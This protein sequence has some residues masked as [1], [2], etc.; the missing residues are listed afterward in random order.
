MKRPSLQST[1]ALLALVVL[2]VATTSRGQE[3]TLIQDD[4]ITESPLEQP[5][6]PS[7]AATEPLPEIEEGQTQPL[8]ETTTTPNGESP[9]PPAEESP[10]TSDDTIKFDPSKSVVR[11]AKVRPK[12]PRA[13]VRVPPAP[14]HSANPE[15]DL[16]EHAQLVAK[17][18][19]WP[20]AER[21]Y[22]VYLETYPHKPNAQAAYYG[23][24]EARMKLGKLAESEATYRMLL[25]RFK[26]GEHVGAAAYRLGYIHWERQE[27]DI[28]V[29]NFEIAS[30]TA[31]KDLVRKSASYFRAQ[32]LQQ[33][34]NL[35]RAEE[36]FL[37]LASDPEDHKYRDASAIMLARID[38]EKNKFQQAYETFSK[39]SKPPTPPKIRAEAV[40]K[41]GLM[42]AKLGMQTEAQQYYEEILAV[43]TQDATPWHPKAF[44]GLLHLFYEQGNYQELIDQ[45]QSRRISYNNSHTG[46]EDQ[47]PVMLMVAHAFRR[48]E[49]YRQAA[50]LYDQSVRLNPDAKEAREAGYRHLYCLYKD[51]SPFLDAKTHDYL[52]K[53][54]QKG[55]GHQYYHLALLLKAESLFGRKQK[56]KETY[57]EAA[58]AYAAI[59]LEMIP[60]KY[61]GM[62]MYK[63]GWAQ[64]EAGM[65]GKGIQSFYTFSTKYG[66][67]YPDLLPK[68]LAKRGEAFRKGKDYRSAVKDFD[69]LIA[70]NADENLV[71]LALQQ[72]ALIQVELENRPE[73]IKTFTAL[74][75]RFPD[76]Q[77]SSEAYFFIGDAHYKQSEFEECVEPLSKARELDGDTYTIPSTQRII[78]AH[79]RL[80]DS[81]NAAKQVDLLL[82]RDPKTNLIPP[83]LWLWLGTRFFQQDRFEASARYLKQVAKPD[84]PKDTWPLAW[85]F[86]GRAYLNSGKYE[87]SLAP[88]DHY[89][90]TEPTSDE[91]AKALLHKAT[92]LSKTGKLKEAQAAAEEVQQLQK[93]GRTYGQAW[94]LL[95]DIAMAQSEHEKASKYYVIPS[96]MF[97]DPLV[98]PIAIEKAAVAFD[99]MGEAQ[100]A[101][102]LRRKL[103]EDWPT[104]QTPADS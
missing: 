98:T 14:K 87:E 10:E 33:L 6:D 7:T 57:K 20:Q 23:L 36:L 70:T 16:F 77:G 56:T 3:P 95:G 71:Y 11:P 1:L 97:K 38:V 35:R 101:A 41:A 84:A 13:P 91:R 48:L 24:A 26:R 39:L 2:L 27:Y 53:Q 85:S 45:F 80:G 102:D 63:L 73:T 21:Q 28:A 86:L 78:V 75:D 37:K 50:S 9:T 64:T 82:A 68:V 8:P 25:S 55:I 40:T 89:L 94:I 12:A 32:C 79:W 51:K 22:R 5:R 103:R 18:E 65:H 19:L 76:G 72:K 66:E 34:G 81:D 93:Q 4:Q 15:A 46:L 47:A 62:V 43:E 29:G 100:R 42:A 59:N 44:W 17:Y 74:L 58:D 60:E 54:R 69:A 61:H 52:I 83:K 49:K 104:Y 90:A 99:K 67:Q 31:T 88:F 30:R 96:R 92:A